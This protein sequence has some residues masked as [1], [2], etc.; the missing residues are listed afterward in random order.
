MTMEY[1]RLSTVASVM[2]VKVGWLRGLVYQKV[3]DDEREHQAKG[4]PYVMHVQQCFQALI[5]YRMRQRNIGYDLIRDAVWDLEIDRLK[6]HEVHVAEGIKL[7]LQKAL[8]TLQARSL[9]K[10]ANDLEFG[11]EE[12]RAA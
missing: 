12:E 10:E 7:V 4:S 9:L 5:A 2:G 3:M 6:R 1:V 8:L 11:V